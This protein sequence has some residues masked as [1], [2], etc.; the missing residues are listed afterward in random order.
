MSLIFTIYIY[1]GIGAINFVSTKVSQADDT[2]PITLDNVSCT[3]SE[4]NLLSC[5]YSRENNCEHR[6]D[7]SVTC[8]PTDF[9]LLQKQGTKTNIYCVRLTQACTYGMH[10]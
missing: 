8:V 3:G 5:D 9:S 4:E 1:T 2:Q 6:E 10:V 7:I